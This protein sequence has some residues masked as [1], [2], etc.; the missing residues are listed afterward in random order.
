VNRA[1]A[2]P[3]T[4]ERAATSSRSAPFDLL[5][6][7]V[8]GPLLSRRG[9][10]RFAQVALGLGALALVLHGLFGPSI[11]PK[12]LATLVTWV[13]Y[14][15]VL[16][17]A[18]LVLGNVFC[19]GCPFLLPR[20]V[21]RR[22]TRPVR[23]LPRPLR[24]KWVAAVLFAGVL[25]AYEVFDLWGAPAGTALLI[26]GYFALALVVDASFRGAP[27]CKYLC[28]IGQFNFLAS[29]LSPLEIAARDPDACA[30]CKTKECIRGERD[31]NGAPKPGGQRGC[32]LA[33]FVPQKVGNLDCTFCL[34]CV[35]ACPKDNVGLLARMPGE[36]LVHAGRRSGI[37]QVLRRPDWAAL[38]I[39]FTF[40]ALL[41]AFGM[42]APVYALERWLADVLGT[43]RES[44]LLA[45]IFLAV[46]VVLPA[47]LFG[48]A[49]AASRG[50]G[51][52]PER[53]REQ[54]TRHAFGLVP[55]GLGVW[56]AHY[57]FH[58]LTGI[59]TIVPVLQNAVAELGAPL[60]GEPNWRL[61]GIEAGLVWPI[62]VGFLALGALGSLAITYRLVD[63]RRGRRVAAY[64]PW[65]VLVL[66]LAATAG[67]LL[68]QPMEMRGTFL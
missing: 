18:L 60:L 13:H 46:L 51:G 36:E 37:G 62:E 22:F 20:E 38:A 52:A 64:A 2:P 47:M 19:F 26:V 56:V 10:R 44:I 8:I 68:A 9:S 25:Y 15:G 63:A 40:G 45:L 1:G 54:A 67:W 41:N 66:A 3:S 7:P 39:V 12:N 27:F 58:F 4:G 28:P 17:V 34:D 50:L 57:A 49:A 31:E 42:V 29:T 35:H 32:E 55:L 43:Q 21:A 24:S 11:A 30:T 61:G 6:V 48:A 59:W 53:L 5:R 16:V 65:A 14:R 23:H 33:L